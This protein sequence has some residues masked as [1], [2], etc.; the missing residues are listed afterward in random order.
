MIQ[1]IPAILDKT[2]EDFQK[3]IE[4]L[5]HSVG[6]KEGWVHIDFADNEF[7]PNQTIRPDI[8]SLFPINLK[9]EAHLMVAHPLDWIEKLQK[10]GFK[11]VIFHF[12][13][14]DN[15]E[16]VIE[17]IKKAGMEAGIAINPETSIDSLESY[18]DK[19][20]QVLIMGI[21]PGFQGQPF[22]PATIDKIKVLKAKSWQVKISVDGAVKDT[23]SLALAEAGVDRLVSGSFLFKGDID[24]NVEKI[25]EVIKGS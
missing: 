12:E 14:K 22:I 10:A 20:D 1:I 18:K 7:V 2:P 11:R 21:V 15:L 13:S 5:K 4:E 17:T 6:F 24:D 25:W 23:N 16:E 8:V 3:H 9:K 19:V